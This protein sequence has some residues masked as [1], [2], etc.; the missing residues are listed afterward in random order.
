MFIYIINVEELCN[1][2]AVSSYNWNTGFELYNMCATQ[3]PFCILICLSLSE[4]EPTQTR[5][6]TERDEKH[7]PIGPLEI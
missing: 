4:S 3:I 6:R 5:G 7:W 1:K 2:M